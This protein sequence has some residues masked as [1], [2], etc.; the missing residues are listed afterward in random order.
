MICAPVDYLYDLLQGKRLQNAH[1]L[2]F[3]V[4]LTNNRHPKVPEYEKCSRTAAAVVSRPSVES[5]VQTKVV[6]DR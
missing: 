2:N 1:Q 6:I 3:I 5:R 4:T